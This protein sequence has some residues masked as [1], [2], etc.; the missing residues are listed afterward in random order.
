METNSIVFFNERQYPIPENRPIVA[1]WQ[2]I[3]PENIGNMVRLADN[4]GAG[5]VFILGNNFNHRM[6]SVKK[7]A[8]LSFANVEL[9][10]ISPEDFF[11]QLEP[12]YSLAAIETC[13]SSTNLFQTRLPE[14]IVFLLGNERHG[15]PDEILNRCMLKLHIPMTGK[16]KSMNV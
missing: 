6:A 14:K 1:A 7:T 13:I 9:K 15:L 11:A 3:N 8:G 10:F 16:C 5:Q 4:V 2:I 12:G